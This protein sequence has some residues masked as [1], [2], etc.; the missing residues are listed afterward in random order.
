MLRGFSWEQGISR[1]MGVTPHLVPCLS[2]NPPDLP[3]GSAY[4]LH[5]DIQHPASLTFSVPPSHRMAVLDY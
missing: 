5:R 3:K 4:T 1:F 2:V